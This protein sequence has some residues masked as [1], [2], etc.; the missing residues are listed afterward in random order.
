[1]RADVA[2]TDGPEERV[3]QGVKDHVCI[4]VSGQRPI[5]RNADAAEPDV[6]SFGEGVHVEALTGPDVEER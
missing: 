3:R 1:M 2:V 5:V 6:V 4:R